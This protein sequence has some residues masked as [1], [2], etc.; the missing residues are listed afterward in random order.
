MVSSGQRL[1][2]EETRLLL[3]AEK[4]SIGKSAPE[5]LACSEKEIEYLKTSRSFAVSKLI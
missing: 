4:E 5:A 1:L 2:S 3:S